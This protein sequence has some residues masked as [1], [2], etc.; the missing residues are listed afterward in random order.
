MTWKERVMLLILACLNFTH[1][2]DFMIMMPL[3]NYLMPHFGIST[4]FFSLVVAAYPITAFVSGIVAAFYVDKFDRKK[5]L[6]WAYVGFIA[7]T[8]CC[9]IAPDPYFLIAA[10]IVTGLFGGLI[11]AQVLSIIADVFPYEKRGRAM[12][13]IFTAF[14]IAS[15]FGVPF[16]LYLAN[17]ISWHAPFI[18]IG[19]VGVFV[20]PLISKFLPSM[21]SHMVPL[22]ELRYKPDVR[23]VLSDMFNNKSQLMALSLS[24]FLM[25]G[26]FLIIPFI[27]P[28]LEF[29]LGFS[30]SQT[31]MVY[32][33]GGACTLVTSPILG[34]M[35]DR[36]G[37]LRIFMIS[38][39][40]SLVPIFLITNMPAIPFV[41]VLA[42]FACWF[43]FSTG[44]NIPAQAMISTV[45][46][47][48]QRGQ[49][50]S[51]NSSFQ[52][53]FTGLA[54]LISGLI[55]TE[56]SNGKISNYDLVGYLSIVIVGGS[57][58]LGILLA[59]KQAIS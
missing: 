43:V 2:L 7:G 42:V 26:H 4:R 46:E 56:G 45:V 14:S 32:M 53:L 33:I 55:V 22:G 35:A 17:L 3:G 51:F 31:P 28:Y 13:T 29:N 20:I 18:F 5:I 57:L 21:T 1:I 54:S 25:L 59:R 44:R 10:R 37:K 23:K 41:Y 49:F 58:Y 12:G 30:K 40:A 52:Q 11:G 15:V 38:L 39:I 50:M 9:G 16:S 47:S 36:F 6:L 34:R 19:I 8:I 27:N 24:A 48:S